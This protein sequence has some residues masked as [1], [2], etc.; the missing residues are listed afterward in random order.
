[1]KLE[2]QRPGVVRMTA[3]VD[4][5]ATLVAGCRMAKHAL[6]SS[7]ERDPDELTRVLADFDRAMRALRLDTHTDS[8]RGKP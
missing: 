5:L 8:E 4:E 7:P 6:D 1:M 2:W 3:K